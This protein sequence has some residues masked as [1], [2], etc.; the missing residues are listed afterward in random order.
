MISIC[1]RALLASAVLLMTIGLAQTASAQSKEDEQGSYCINNPDKCGAGQQYRK[2][3]SD[4]GY[5]DEQETY[6][7]KRRYQE[8]DQAGDYTDKPSMKRAQG[9]W[10]YDPQSAQAPSPQG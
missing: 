3:R 1:K 10:K 2:P 7:R 8:E 5:S 4:E 9:D 6:S